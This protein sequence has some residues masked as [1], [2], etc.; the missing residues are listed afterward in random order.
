MRVCGSRS[1]SSLRRPMHW[2]ARVRARRSRRT[3]L[4]EVSSETVDRAIVPAVE[5]CVLT[6]S[7]VTEDVRVQ[8]GT[9]LNA[10]TIVG[11]GDRVQTGADVVARKAV[12]VDLARDR[13]L[14]WRQ[15]GPHV[16][17]ISQCA[18]L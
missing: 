4:G 6:R 1:R 17:E 15:N 16:A 8:A 11:E 10:K 18:E 9:T 13:L 5:S 12:G 3:A 14:I 2:S 7:T